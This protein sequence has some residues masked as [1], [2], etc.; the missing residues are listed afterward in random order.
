MS[1]TV[2]VELKIKP[3]HCDEFKEFMKQGVETTR[4]FEGCQLVEAFENADEPFSFMFYE[5]WTDRAAHEKYFVFQQ[6]AGAVDALAPWM[7]EPPVIR[8]FNNLGV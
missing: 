5:T 7:A 3:E 4:S 8:Y 1:M 6:E 2:L